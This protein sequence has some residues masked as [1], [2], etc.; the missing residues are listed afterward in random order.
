MAAKRVPSDAHT[1]DACI[2]AMQMSPPSLFGITFAAT[3]VTTD[4]I[5]SPETA[6]TMLPWL[7]ASYVCPAVV[8]KDNW[9]GDDNYLDAFKT[10]HVEGSLNVTRTDKNEGWEMELTFECC[11]GWWAR[12]GHEVYKASWP[13]R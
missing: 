2:S 12:D 7:D 1:T 4:I 5:T 10:A 9:L 13:L 8:N 6:N 11:K 3:C